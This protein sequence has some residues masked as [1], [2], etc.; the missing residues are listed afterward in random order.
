MCHY[1]MVNMSKV[2]YINVF[3]FQPLSLFYLRLWLMPFSDNICA[4][5][6]L[7][8]LKKS[9]DFVNIIN[10]I[11]DDNTLIFTRINA[12]YSILNKIFL[13]LFSMS[14]NYTTENGKMDI[15]TH[16]TKVVNK[17]TTL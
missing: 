6:I 1:K 2:I 4:S 14:V 15:Q 13:K 5:Y 12:L 11:S 17:L 7:I 10:I 9:I 16:S 8:V 3:M